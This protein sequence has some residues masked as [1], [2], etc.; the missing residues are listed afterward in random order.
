MT[1]FLDTPEK[2]AAL[3][4][5]INNLWSI[6]KVFDA[7]KEA[8]IKLDNQG[9]MVNVLKTAYEAQDIDS[10]E[11]QKRAEKSKIIAEAI[12]ASN[13]GDNQFAIAALMQTFGGIQEKKSDKNY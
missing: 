10:D 7:L 3:T 5:E 13:A 11:A 1:K 4:K 12:H 6:D 9:D 8:T 2:L